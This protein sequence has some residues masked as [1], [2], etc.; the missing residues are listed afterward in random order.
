VCWY[1]TQM[2]DNDD[3]PTHVTQ[4]GPLCDDVTHMS[5]HVTHM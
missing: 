4:H 2:V 3:V 1:A 5:D